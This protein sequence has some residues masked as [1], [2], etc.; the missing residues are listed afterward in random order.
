MSEQKA[1]Q[2]NISVSVEWGVDLKDT[3][4][5]IS[6]PG[7]GMVEIPFLENQNEGEDQNK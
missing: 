5:L 4:F 6:I 3:T 1:K 7:L 2:D